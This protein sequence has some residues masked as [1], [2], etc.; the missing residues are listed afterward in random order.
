M[1]PGLT[2]PL[3]WHCPGGKSYLASRIV[4]LMPVHTHYVE[5]YFGGGA[6]LLATDP[7]GRSEVVNDIDRLLTNFWDVLRVRRLFD[8]LQR[9]VEATPFSRDA[10]D[11]AQGWIASLDRQTPGILLEK[12]SVRVYAAWAFFVACRQSLAGRMGSFAPL[13]RN[14]TRRGMNEQASAWL[15][16]VEGLPEV[17]TRLKRVVVEN[18][19][20]TAVIR[21][22]DG[23]NTL[24]Y[25]DP[26]YLDETRAT[27]DVY[28]H[29]MTRDQH[30]DLLDLANELEGYVM[31]SGYRS[32]LYDEG[33][34]GWNRHDFDLP[35][36]AAGGAAKRRMVECV[37]CN[38]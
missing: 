37:W 14:R 29:E 17:H 32:G 38:F 26:P 15:T 10:F 19:E 22:E 25:L 33:L 1:R 23:P 20:A 18:D 11:Q 31:I 35:N 4:R 5:P 9:R 3:K 34:L 7:E 6:V 8:E 30:G 27:P 21:R 2:G 24:H 28:A 36:H 12:E 13:S 16:A